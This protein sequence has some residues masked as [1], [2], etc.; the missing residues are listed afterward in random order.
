MIDAGHGKNTAG[1]RCLKKLDQKETGEWVLNNRVADALETYLISAGHMTMR[2]DDTSGKK[3]VPLATRVRMLMNGRQI[4]LPL[5]IIMQELMVEQVEVLLC[6]HIR[7][8]QGKRTEPRK[9]F[10]SMQLQGLN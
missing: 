2:V 3:D 1:R 7:V 9:Q 8:F 4:I 6:L 5:F 10:I